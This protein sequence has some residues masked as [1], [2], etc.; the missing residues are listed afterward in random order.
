MKKNVPKLLKEII[1]EQLCIDGSKI[2]PD[3]KF[4][5]DLG[6]DSLD[7]VELLMAVEEEFG[8]EISDADAEK[9]TTVGEAQAYI[10]KHLKE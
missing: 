7:A 2:T 1:E 10:E 6:C 9:I 4:I 3:A 8:L 5:D